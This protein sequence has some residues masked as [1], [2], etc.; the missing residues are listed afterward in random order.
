MTTVGD[1]GPPLHPLKRWLARGLAATGLGRLRVGSR[2]LRAVNYHATPRRHADDFRRHLDWYQRNFCNVSL[3]DLDSFF[4]TGT[5]PREKP[6][7]ILTFDDGRLD[8]H[9][10]A[11]PLIEEAGFV[12]WFFIPIGFVETPPADQFAFAQTHRIF[13]FPSDAAA[14]RLAMNWE[15]I[16]DLD[17]RGHV[18]CAHTWTHRRLG[19]SASAEILDREIRGAKEKLDAE[20]GRSTACFGWVG[21]EVESCSL[22]A[23]RMIASSGYRYAF[24]NANAVVTPKTDPFRI[25]RTNI[26]A[27]WPLDVVRFQLCGFMDAYS[28]RKRRRIGRMLNGP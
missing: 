21:G 27:C 13:H 8:N 14:A 17:R 1:D 3:A 6:G 9:E 11:L 4:S 22:A 5:W 15:E 19:A 24:E 10:V 20:V 23:G 18:V 25:Q 7:L 12:G 26:E 2:F 16:R 28:W